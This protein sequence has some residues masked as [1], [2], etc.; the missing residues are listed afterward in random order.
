MK[1]ERVQVQGTATVIAGAK[2]VGGLASV[3]NES[4]PGSVSMPTAC[5]IRV[6]AGALTVY[7]GGSA[8]S[9]STGCPVEA[10][11]DITVDLVNEILYAA[12]SS[13]TTSQ[14][15]YILRRGD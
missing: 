15:V 1:G 2:T 10:G 6:P 5:L 9:A 11:E 14:V 3:L 4:G 12:I 8:V 13:Q 7:F